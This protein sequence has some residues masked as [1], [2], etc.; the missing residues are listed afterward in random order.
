MNKNYV[1][2]T[3]NPRV[4]DG[5]SYASNIEFKY[6][7]NYN[8]GDIFEMMKDH[9]HKG[10]ILETHPLSSSLK[11]NETPY[12]S[13]LLKK[14]KSSEVDT[15]S[16]LIS[17]DALT[18]YYKFQD[19]RKTPQWPDHIL[20]EFSEIDHSIISFAIDKVVR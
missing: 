1:V 2:L 4:Y 5:Y 6:D 16:L 9:V 10:W 17:E 3:N 18:F 15:Q 19:D 14:S 20:D 8:Y 7:E 13:I 12:K 11:P